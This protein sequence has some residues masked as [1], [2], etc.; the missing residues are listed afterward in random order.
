M[1][2]ADFGAVERALLEGEFVDCRLVRYSSN[3]VFLAILE[4]PAGELPAIY[5]PE[6]GE[7]PLWDFPEGTLY[8]REAAAYR[9][10]RAVGWCFVPPTVVRD[11]PHGVGA[12]Q[13]FVPHDPRRHYFEQREHPELHEQLQR[14]VLFDAIANNADR[15]A[16]HCLLDRDGKVWGID[17]GLC[18]HVEDKLRTVMWDWA[19]SPIPERLYAELRVVAEA[20]EAGAT[21]LEGM[22]ELISAEEYRAT[23]RRARALVEGGRFPLPGQRRSYPW[24]LV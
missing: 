10:A 4:T 6:R 16:G 12:L 5:K 1:E 8:R 22:R 15:K 23:V 2:L 19:G 17:H 18:F 3:Y 11:G 9:F 20:L 21:A 7:A 24:P 13:A 14:I